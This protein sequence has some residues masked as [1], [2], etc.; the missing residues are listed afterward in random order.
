[1]ETT[2]VVRMG[3][4]LG[5][6]GGGGGREEFHTNPSSILIF[7]SWNSLELSAEIN[8]LQT[9]VGFFSV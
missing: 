7:E 4:C 1:M 3:Q 2:L 8:T 5:G 6:G 9:L